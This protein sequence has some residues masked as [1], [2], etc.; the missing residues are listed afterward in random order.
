[1]LDHAQMPEPEDGRMVASLIPAAPSSCEHLEEAPTRGP[2]A[3]IVCEECVALGWDW[4]HVRQCLACGHLG[5]C[6]S[7]RGRHAEAHFHATT[8]PVMGSA[9]PGE[10]WRWCYLDRIVG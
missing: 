8:Q 7:S 5:C 3:D 9:E 1:M 4:V 10:S 2:P 6:D